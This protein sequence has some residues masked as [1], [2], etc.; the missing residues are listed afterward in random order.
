[1]SPTPT[2]L[3]EKEN[4]IFAPKEVAPAVGVGVGVGVGI[5]VGGVSNGTKIYHAARFQQ[6]HS[7]AGESLANLLLGLKVLGTNANN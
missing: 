4:C 6:L 1:M 3:R 5:G 2:Q 7:G